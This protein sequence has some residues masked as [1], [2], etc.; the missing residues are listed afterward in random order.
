[1]KAW[2]SRIRKLF[3]VRTVMVITG[4]RKSLNL[5]CFCG[6]AGAMHIDTHV[7]VHGGGCWGKLLLLTFQLW[8][9][10]FANEDKS[11]KPS[12]AYNIFKHK[13]TKVQ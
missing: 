2:D 5:W 12:N 1:M 3:R 7:H 9:S 13:R 6:K 8:E 11:N 10:F 4:L